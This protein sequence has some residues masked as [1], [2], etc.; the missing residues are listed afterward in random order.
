MNQTNLADRGMFTY[1]ALNTMIWAVVHFSGGRVLPLD[2][3]LKEVYNWGMGKKDMPT[4]MLRLEEKIFR[5]RQPASPSQKDVVELVDVA[6]VDVSSTRNSS[7][8]S[9][10]NVT[11]P[12]PTLPQY[13][14]PLHHQS[15]SV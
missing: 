1:I 5:K 11:L 13:P 7:H 10:K 3:K 4:W 15:Y 6:N 2:Y 8:H 9:D 14:L 12:P